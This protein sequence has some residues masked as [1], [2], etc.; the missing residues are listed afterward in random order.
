MAERKI[1]YRED[2]EFPC[3][4]ITIERQ[5]QIYESHPYK[6]ERSAILW[7]A[8]HQN[9]KWLIRLLELTLSSFPSYSRHDASHA[10]AVLHNI[11]RILGEDRIQELSATDCFAILHTVYVHDIG[12]AILASDRENIVR[13][14]DFVEMLDM[15]TEGADKDLKNAALQL[16]K[17]CYFNDKDEEIDYEGMEYHQKKKSLYQE[18]LKT[19]Y[20]VVQLLAEYQRKQ[21]GEKSASNVKDWLLDEDKL[22]SEFSMSG[23]PMR[24]F[25]RIADCARLHTDWDFNHIMDLPAEENGYENDMLHPRFVAVL[26]QLGDA[27]DIDNDRF[28]PFAQALLGQLPEQ[29][30]SHYDKHLAVRTLKITPEEILIEADCK[31]REAMRLIK[32]ECDGIES[33]LK[34]ASYSW[35][36]IAPRG[37]S[38]ALPSFHPPK[39]LLDGIE[40]PLDLAMTRFVISQQKA[41]SLLQG[42]NIY[43]GYFPF[44]RELLQNAIDTTK[45]QCYSDYRT[46][47][48][49]RMAGK[50]DEVLSLDIK[51]LS[52]VIDPAQYPIEISIKCCKLTQEDDWKEVDITDVPDREKEKEKYG[53]LFSIKD[54]GTGI[55][56][57]ALRAISSVGTSYKKRKKLLRE[58]PDWLRP[59]GEFGIGLQSVFLISDR[60]YCDTFVRTGERYRI[61]FLTG[62]KSERGYINVLPKDAEEES[63]AYGTEFQVFIS[64][65][66]KKVRNECMN[67]WSGYDPF[68]REYE[69]GKIRRDLIA[70]TVQILTDIDGQLGDMLFPVYTFVDF[71]LGNEQMNQLEQTLKKIIFCHSLKKRD[72]NDKKLKQNISWLYRKEADREFHDNVIYFEIEDGVCR[73]DLWKMQINL[74]LDDLSVNTCLGVERLVQEGF[75]I[76]KSPCKLYYKGILIETRYIENSGN[77]LEYIDIYGGRKGRKLIQLNRNGFTKE[78]EAYVNNIIIPKIYEKLIKVLETLA[79]QKFLPDYKDQEYKLSMADKM[80]ANLE[81]A[82]KESQDDWQRQLVGISLYYNFFMRKYEEGRRDYSSRKIQEKKE[83]WQEALENAENTIR[84]EVQSKSL[85]QRTKISGSV[86]VIE[87][88]M[89]MNHKRNIFEVLGEV[90]INLA[91]FYDRKN[92][93]AVISKRREKGDKWINSLIWLKGTQGNIVSDDNTKTVR[94]KLI[95]VIEERVTE[96]STWE[97]KEKNL[98]AWAEFFLKNVT[99]VVDYQSVQQS[100]LVLGLL[101]S[102]SISACFSD[103]TGNL[104]IHILSEKTMGGVYYNIHAKYMLL[105]LMKKRNRKTKAKRFAGN[106][107]MGYEL[108]RVNE[109]QEDVCKV[110]EEYIGEKDGF[111]L[112]PCSGEAAGELIEFAEGK[113]G[114]N[115]EEAYPDINEKLIRAVELLSACTAFEYQDF[116][117]EDEE[118]FN[119]KYGEHCRREKEL[120]KKEGFT[121][122]LEKGYLLLL[123]KEL[124]KKWEL[125]KKEKNKEEKEVGVEEKNRKLNDDYKNV[126]RFVELEDL[127]KNI[128]RQLMEDEKIMTASILYTDDYGEAG[129]MKLIEK[130]IQYCIR[131]KDVWDYFEEV[132]L[133]EKAASIKNIFW[134]QAQEKDNMIIWTVR[135]TGREQDATEEYYD[136]IWEDFKKAIKLQRK[137]NLLKN[138]QYKLLDWMED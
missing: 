73:V 111:M 21:H 14:D 46:S 58:M 93:F 18:K 64:H 55:D 47:S 95:E 90:E 96:N 98:E 130:L 11:E 121:I 52:G 15:L 60:F 99:N 103:K 102:V 36:R 137:R 109:V 62:A 132:K 1:F 25:F 43:S 79:V 13:S 3:A 89:Y 114:G 65:D 50:P 31:T 82:I 20:A 39:L 113:S 51:N 135:Q 75:Q 84:K 131:W 28:H 5:L 34:S 133:E 100:D 7:H 42:E 48:R 76:M 38:G 116:V 8:W 6:S 30:Q 117:A 83:Q 125:H 23:I 86:K 35:S 32:N 126:T 77:L 45:L 115:Q 97:N 27:L 92:K 108:L 105:K 106:V 44:V 122:Q 63:M 107:W 16:K 74:W 12:M 9:K 24:I 136:M 19:Y 68:A 118:L 94:P 22:R 29:S 37:F 17:N 53:I 120:L 71:D 104:K 80:K 4:K 123:Q 78:G 26:L 91:D 87:L 56:T 119:K 49:F 110:K 40:I 101:Q 128:I 81:K 85:H 33:L 59:T 69:K 129:I 88:F 57:E 124:K 66:K 10:D 112:L 134:T 54:Y 138:H 67:A 2:Q 70:L 61:E 72:Y 127:R 41:F